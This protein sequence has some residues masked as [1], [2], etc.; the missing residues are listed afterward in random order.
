MNIYRE[1]RLW[2]AARKRLESKNKTK[3]GGKKR[4][5]KKK[6]AGVAVF[7]PDWHSSSRH[8]IH[9]EREAQVPLL[10]LPAQVYDNPNKLWCAAQ[11]LKTLIGTK[12]NRPCLS[13]QRVLR[14]W[15]CVRS[16]PLP[17]RPTIN[18]F[19]SLNPTP[20]Q[21]AISLS[22]LSLSTPIVRPNL[23]FSIAFSVPFTPN[24]L[25]FAADL[26]NIGDSPPPTER[27]G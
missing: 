9:S 17:S 5:R 13:G 25:S 19:L 23:W 26:I 24:A 10:L 22:S 3:W 6:K 12:S 8:V 27:K 11:T 4:K 2:W 14:E 16:S 1:P 15:L 21:V 7:W 20:L 18:F